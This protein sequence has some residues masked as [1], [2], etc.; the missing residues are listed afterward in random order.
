MSPS[1]KFLTV[2]ALT[3]LVLSGC[4]TITKEQLASAD[5]GA[6]PWDAETIVKQ[7][8]ESV[9][10]DPE[11]ARYGKMTQPRKWYD[12]NLGNPIFGYVVCLHINSKN[13]LG[14]YTGNKGFAALIHGREV[15]EIAEEGKSTIEDGCPGYPR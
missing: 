2:T 13:R 6:Y 5:Y 4:A 10:I 1:I 12:S 9:L 8:F 3:T 15:V 11:S 14:G 7:H